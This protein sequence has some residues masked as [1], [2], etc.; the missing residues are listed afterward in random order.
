MQ[1]LFSNP[2]QYGDANQIVSSS[3][4][5]RLLNEEI[6]LLIEEWDRL[7]TEAERVTKELEE[8]SS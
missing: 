3:E 7:S 8:S 4:E 6:H 5:Y 2:D 1:W